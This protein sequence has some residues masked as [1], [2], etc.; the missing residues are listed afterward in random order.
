MLD[1]EIRNMYLKMRK[2]NPEEIT[3]QDVLRDTSPTVDHEYNKYKNKNKLWED[4]ENRL[5][6][7]HTDYEKLSRWLFRTVRAIKAQKVNLK[8]KAR[9]ARKWSKKMKV[10]YR[11]NNCLKTMNSPGQC[12]CMTL[13]Y[14]LIPPDND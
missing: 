14:T 7:M 5:I 12:D 4:W 11:C 8:R 10:K 2:Q 9:M 6:M 1:D 3:I 13:N